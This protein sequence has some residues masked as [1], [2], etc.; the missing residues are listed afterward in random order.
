[1]S[2]ELIEMM[3][4]D[5]S[6]VN[7]ARVSYNKQSKWAIW[8]R[9]SY[10]SRDLTQA[11]IE[12][13]R[14]QDHASATI[15][16]KSGRL[17]VADAGLISY[18]AR[19]RHGTPFEMV[20]FKFRVRCPIG[21]AREWQRHRIGS[22]NEVSTRYVEMEPEF[23]VPPLDAMRRQTGK[24]GHYTMESMTADEAKA[25]LARFRLIY[26]LLYSTYCNLLKDGVAKELARNVLPLGLMTEFIWSVNLRSLTNFLSL[27][28]ADNALLEIRTEAKQVE[29]HVAQVVPVAYQAW[30]DGGR[31]AL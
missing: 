26:E 18:L 29:S 20:Q 27:R 8:R 25:P 17:K 3:G 31:Q 30:V 10:C 2:V 28:T 12:A 7:A 22:F 23:Y 13:D 1:M 15:L 19:N 5:L 4:D 11:E 14:C 6:I 21:V 9:C 16:R 24:A